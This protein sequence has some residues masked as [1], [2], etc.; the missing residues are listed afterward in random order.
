M[1][2]HFEWRPYV[3]V[4][5]RKANARAYAT[6]LA[7]KEKRTLSPVELSGNKISSSFWGKAWCE[8]LE[9]YSDYSNRL[10]RG[11]TYVRNG[12]VIDLQIERGKVKA[13][14][15]G[16]EIYRVSIEI[17]TVPAPVWS[18]IKK[19][20]SHSVDSL[21][22]LLQGRFDQGIMQRLTQRESGLFPQPREI[23]MSCSC[24]DSAGMCKHIAAT[25]Y[26]VGARLDSSPELLFT[27]R[28]VDHLE[29]ISQA[30]D[31]DNLSQTLKGK[32]DNTLN[33]SDLGA[34]FG[35]DIEGTKQAESAA[36][37]REPKPRGNPKPK[38]VASRR[39]PKVTKKA[40]VAKK[41][42]KVPARS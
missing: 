9:R 2:W 6:K 35:I 21:I 8:N 20:C 38:A 3:P 16:S 18:Q 12:S 28:D 42:R 22:D 30:V 36:P 27:L 5:K 34:I 37:P 11:R 13:L 19:D 15:S 32:N 17:K 33:G 25:L 40:A 10:P 4:A 7:K 41:K 24:P 26:G 39:L 1:S 31:A 23:K 14:V 29:L